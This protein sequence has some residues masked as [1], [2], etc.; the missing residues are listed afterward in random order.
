MSAPPLVAITCRAVS[1]TETR[2]ALARDWLVWFRREGLRPLLVPLGLE[3]P[4]EWLAALRPAALLFS[5]GNDLGPA[6]GG[7]SPPGPSVDEARD[8]GERALLAHALASGL[9]ALGVCRGFQLISAHQG[10]TLACVAPEK[11]HVGTHAVELLGPLC[12]AGERA[13]VNSFHDQGV[14][15][16]GLPASLELLARSED[17]LAEAV[18]VRGAPAWAIQWHPERRGGEVPAT[19]WVVERWRESF[20]R[21]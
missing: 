2:D 9:P 1:G 4:V 16:A 11:A 19:R 20:E 17:G 3:D 15:V 14:I 7:L 21:G 8:R 10:A 5:G 12:A 6:A 18:R 13:T